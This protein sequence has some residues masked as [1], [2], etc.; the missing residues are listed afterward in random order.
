[1]HATIEVMKRYLIECLA[2]QVGVHDLAKAEQKCASFEQ[3]QAIFE[4][5][6]RRILVDLEAQKVEAAEQLKARS[7][8][9][10]PFPHH[11]P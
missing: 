10:L 11:N 8:P 9:K 1:M 7:P 3:E 4:E 5:E 6:Y 2:L